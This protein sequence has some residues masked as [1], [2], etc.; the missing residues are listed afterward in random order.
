VSSIPRGIAGAIFWALV[1]AII[2]MLVRPN[3]PAGGAV[4]ALANAMAAM[5]AT[6]TGAAATGN[7]GSGS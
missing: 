5:I 6:A 1:L 3:S 7:G 2:Y 4:I